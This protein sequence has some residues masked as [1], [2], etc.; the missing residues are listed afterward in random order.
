MLL[1]RRLSRLCLFE[2]PLAER[3]GGL[4]AGCAHGSFGVEAVGSS[5]G[6]GGGVSSVV[7]RGGSKQQNDDK[8]DRGSRLALH[9]ALLLRLLHDM[10]YM[11]M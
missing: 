6:G 5:G 2:L 10:Y 8:I 11:Y 1:T 3:P 7:H 9:V 4:G